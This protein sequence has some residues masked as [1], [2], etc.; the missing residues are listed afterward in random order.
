MISV[1]VPA[2]NE[3]ESVENVMNRI[4]NTM[5]S[6]KEKYEILVID[7]GSKDRTAEILE[8]LKFVSIIKHPYNKGYGAALK[9]GIR[10]AKGDW[11][12]ITDADGTYPVEDIPKLMEHTHNHDMI[13]GARTGL[14]VHIPATR[15]PAKFMLAKMA[16]YIAGNNIPDLNSGLRIF[17]KDLA[18]RFFHIFPSGF[19]FTSTI[20]LASFCN[21]YSVKYVPINYEKRKGKSKMKASDFFGFNKLFLKMMMYFDPMKIFIPASAIV[22]AIGITSLL[23]DIIVYQNIADLSVFLILA[24]LQIGLIGLVA[25]LVA[26]EKNRHHN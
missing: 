6:T 26:I 4:K 1:I 17:K 16:N 21:D 10:N 3:E 5:D 22:G 2:Y 13:V 8:K 14:N 9:T 7:D 20:T 24:A 15:R 25:D 11:I 23:F 18:L 19:S 12:L